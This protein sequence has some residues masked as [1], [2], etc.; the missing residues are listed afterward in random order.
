ML[1]ESQERQERQEMHRLLT[2]GLDCSLTLTQRRHLWLHY[3]NGLTVRQI[4]E[5]EG[6]QHPSI[7]ECLTAAKKKLMAFL[8]NMA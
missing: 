2:E 7:V 4:A 1:I 5:A 6:I 3:V 8:K